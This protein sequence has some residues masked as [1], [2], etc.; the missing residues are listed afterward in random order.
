MHIKSFITSVLVFL[1]SLSINGN[2]LPK[3]PNPPRLVNDLA[4][5]LAPAEAQ[6]LERILQDFSNTTSNQVV[7]LSVK[8][9][10]GYDVNDFASRVGEEWGVGQKEFD[11]GIVILVKPKFGNERG[12]VSIQVGYG[13]E[14]IIPDAIA[15]RIIENEIIPLFKQDRNYEGII[16]GISVLQ[17]L[18]KK[19]YSYK[20]YMKK[21]GNE[22]TG[23][24]PFIIIIMF[25][26]VFLSGIFGKVRRARR[27]SIGHDI[28]FWVALSMI[29]SSSS[30]RHRGS[31][32]G[33]SS[34]SGGFGGFGG[35]GFGGGGASGSW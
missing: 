4:Q 28:P 24:A 34:G 7:F 26:S 23:I 15:K 22:G 32:S 3:R 12:Q 17:N 19:E 8:D 9:L 2:D 21:S 35:G 11:N 20:D 25:L 10:K 16:A 27:Y 30:G 6:N 33:F 18:A 5:F 14:G 31:Y 13:L 1:F 29:S